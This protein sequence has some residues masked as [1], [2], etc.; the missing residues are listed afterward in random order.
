MNDR[1]ATGLLFLF[2]ILAA[3]A[4]ERAEVRGGADAPERGPLRVLTVNEPLAY[5]AR[6]IGGDDV[7]A[8]YPG[9]ADEDPSFWSPGRDALREFQGAD[10]ILLNGAGYAKWIE[11]ASLPAARLV[12]TSAAF[13]DRLIPLDGEV[14]HS[15][16]PEGEHSHVGTELTTWIDPTLAILHAR[17]ILDAL[18]ERRPERETR[19]TERFGTLE[20]EL[21]A[22]DEALR[23]AVGKDPDRALVAS[24]PVYAYLAR[25]YGLNLRSV[26]W[27][28]DTV[29]DEAAWRELEVLLESHP[30]R[31]MMWEGEPLPEVVRRLEALGLGSF[32]FD[33]C[34]APPEAGDWA[35]VMRE[36]AE[37]LAAAF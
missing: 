37:A 25:R 20:T 23:T 28:P 24:H 29:P 2:L 17:A 7:E 3:C 27:E 18:V 13:T 4:P 22:L 31:W 30:A 36:N 34:A 12:D 1:H 5:F 9:P 11:R 16:G 14:T 32:V 15:H 26:H 19:F 33:P 10:L 35:S 21:G 8:R 6:R